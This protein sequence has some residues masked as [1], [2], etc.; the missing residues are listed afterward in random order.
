MY[1]YSAVQW[2]FIFYVYGFLGWCFESTVVSL[3]ERRLIS[4][5]FL[6]GPILP[7]YGTGAVLLLL[8]ALPLRS[9][10]PALLFLAGMAAATVLEYVTGALLETLFKVKYWDYSGHKMQF[11]GR[12]CLESSLTWGALTLIL[13]G[14]IQPSIER[15]VFWLSAAALLTLV[16]AISGIF[17]ADVVLSV[18]TAIDLARVL[19]ELTRLRAQADELR[20]QLSAMAG[21]TRERLAEA[22]GNTRE[23]LSETALDTR[24]R[25]TE[26][27]AERR[28]SLQEALDASTAAYEQRIR[29]IRLAGRML[30]RAYP[31]AVSA[32]F[33]KAL[34]ELKQ[35]LS[36][37]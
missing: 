14:L 13:T 35:R 37:R 9:Q 15:F 17:V 1:A 12:I 27:A 34:E 8:V 21:E 10:P 2:L 20:Q 22:A 6:H 30:V 18:H 26:A 3:Q 24:E 4:R 36:Q 32:K 5:G 33:G 28:R 25:L 29:K 19:S 31:G 16:I 7:L 23:K 11:Q